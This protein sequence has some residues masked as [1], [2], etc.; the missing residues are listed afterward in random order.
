MPGLIVSRPARVTVGGL[1]GLQIDLGLERGVRTC[2]Y[3]QYK[4]IPLIIGD[5]TSSLH[6]VIL[7]ELDVRLVILAWQRGNVT[8][9]ITN[10]KKQHTAA[11]FRADL[12]PI[13][14]SL[15]FQG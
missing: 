15:R 12:Q 9:E 4:G 8:L 5:G 1:R 7:K 11:E 14:N 13:V 6:H 10:E 2:R 3:N